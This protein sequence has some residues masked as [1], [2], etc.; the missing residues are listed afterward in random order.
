[1][2]ID[3]LVVPGKEC[4][5]GFKADT[6]MI[7]HHKES[8]NNKDLKILITG[9]HSG[10]TENRGFT[11]AERMRQYLSGNLDDDEIIVSPFGRD[12]YSELV[13]ASKIINKM[14][15]KPKSIGLVNDPY[16]MNRYLRLANFVM[17][18]EFKFERIET[19]NI[20]NPLDVFKEFLLEKSLFYDINQLWD[21]IPEKG[22]VESHEKALNNNHIFYRDNPDKITGYYDVAVKLDKLI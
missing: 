1:M 9:E 14:P 7:H 11:D 13:F 5:H 8:E 20:A 10:L 19:P 22:D 17:G 3:L 16:A 12:L 15:K 18:D 4:K 21:T 6:A 2:T